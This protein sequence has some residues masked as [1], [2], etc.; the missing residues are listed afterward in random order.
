MSEDTELGS[1]ENTSDEQAVETEETDVA[2]EE[3]VSD[4]EEAVET[5]E[6]E[7]EE[8]SEEDSTEPELVEVEYDGQKYQVPAEI[9]DSL[10]RTQDYT[11]KTQDHAETVKAHE[12]TVTDFNAAQAVSAEVHEADFKVRLIDNKISQY[13]GIDWNLAHQQ[14]PAE[15]MRLEMQLNRLVAERQTAKDDLKTKSDAFNEQ[16]GV[17]FAKT[18]EKSS[19]II[20]KEIADWGPEK[21]T[22]MAELAE[23]VGFSPSQIA[24]I[25]SPSE[26]RILD[27]ALDGMKFRNLRQ[28]KGKPGKTDKPAV[29]VKKVSTVK[30]V[31]TN[32]NPD[33][34]SVKEWNAWREKQLAKKQA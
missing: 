2:V 26:I 27:L 28:V 25:S 22:A 23:K 19:A 10:M 15:A 13:D 7:S 14:N 24:Q 6:T 5:S 18:I 1:V 34:M 32:K 16:R 9:K 11:V 8:V 3:T 12:Q 29:P 31:A 30:S 17:A 21:E 33:D 20:S 4:T